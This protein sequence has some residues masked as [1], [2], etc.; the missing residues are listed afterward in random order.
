MSE[1]SQFISA[2]FSSSCQPENGFTE[3]ANFT[4]SLQDP[5]W[6]PSVCV[7]VMDRKF[8]V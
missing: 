5:V 4:F 8:G 6:L 1:F 2:V 3:K 7:Y